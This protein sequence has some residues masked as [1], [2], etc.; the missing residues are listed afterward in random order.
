M[1][2]K[3]IEINGMQFEFMPGKGW[4]EFLLMQ[5]QENLR[6]KERNRFYAFVNLEKT[7]LLNVKRRYIMGNDKVGGGGGQRQH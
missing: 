6:E 4:M 1:V 5:M 3:I 7:C 2:R